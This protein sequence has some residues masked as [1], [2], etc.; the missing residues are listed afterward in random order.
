MMLKNLN[1]KIYQE[2]ES[3]LEKLWTN[4]EKDSSNYYFQTYHWQKSWFK[5][6]KKYKRKSI[7]IYVIV[8]KND[9]ETLFI[10]PF[11]IYKILFIK[12]LSWSGFPFSDY[13]APLINK[14]LNINKYDFNY[15]WKLIIKKNKNKY[16]CIS[17]VNQPNMINNKPNPFFYYLKTH[18]SGLYSG[19]NLKNSLIYKNNELSDIRYQKNRLNKIGNLQ[20]K[21]AKDK[22]EKKK[23]LRFLIQNK[24]LQYKKTNA[25]NLFEINAY[26]KFFIQCNLMFNINLSYLTLDRKIIAAHS[27]YVYDQKYYYLFPT[28]DINFKKYSP[29]KILLKYLIDDCKKNNLKYFDFTIGSE[30]YKKNWSNN[31]INSGMTNISLNIIGFLYISFINFKIKAKSLNIKNNFLLNLYNKFKS[32]VYKS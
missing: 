13:N 25:W 14:N 27:G 16:D 19:I 5:Q 15:I 26:K 18:K 30:D 29:G 31:K 12:V 7:S 10:L 24:I 22:N 20:F 6:M 23:V 4:F 2:L 21:F 8:V 9:Q 32:S 1:I 17:L 3:E 28:Y 11:C